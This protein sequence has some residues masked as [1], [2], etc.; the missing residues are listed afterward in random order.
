M[1][2]L[3]RRISLATIESGRLSHA[4]KV[5]YNARSSKNSQISVFSVAGTFSIGSCWMKSLIGG[6]EL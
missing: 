3:S 1:L 4:R 5:T 2:L 6:S